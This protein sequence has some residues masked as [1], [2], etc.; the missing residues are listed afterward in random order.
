MTKAVDLI[1][2]LIDPLL[3]GGGPSERREY[4]FRDHPSGFKDEWG[5]LIQVYQPYADHPGASANIEEDAQAFAAFHGLELR[6]SADESWHDPGK[7]V[8]VEF[9]QSIRPDLDSWTVGEGDLVRR[10]LVERLLRAGFQRYEDDI[11]PTY[12]PAS[13]RFQKGDVCVKVYKDYLWASTSVVGSRLGRKGA[14]AVDKVRAVARA[15][16]LTKAPYKFG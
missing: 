10:L 9:S 6:I 8:L 11:A 15:I 16:Q 14:G 7:T 13:V 4:A 1:Y 3:P 12:G 2:Q 5:R